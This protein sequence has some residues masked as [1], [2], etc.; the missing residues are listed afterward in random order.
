MLGE[1]EMKEDGEYIVLNGTMYKGNNNTNFKSSNGFIQLRDIFFAICEYKK[2]YKQNYSYY[3]NKAKTKGYKC[4]NS[5]ELTDLENYLTNVTTDNNSRT[6]P[7]RQK[8]SKQ[9][10]SYILPI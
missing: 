7:K 4:L 9:F 2:N 10:S 5:Y 3:Y 1:K 8:I 6:K